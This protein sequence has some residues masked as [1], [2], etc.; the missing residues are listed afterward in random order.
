MS[1]LKPLLIGV[2]LG[3]TTLRAGLVCNGEVITE[4]RVNADLST[5]CAQASPEQALGFVVDALIEGI[6]AIQQKAGSEIEAIGISL[7]GY[8]DGDSGIIFSSPNLP[9][10]HNAD[11]ATPLSHHFGAEIRVENDAL[12]ATWGEFKRH[13]DQPKHMIYI[14]LGTGIGGGLILNEKPYRGAHGMAMEIGHIVIKPEGRPCGCGKQ[15][16]VERYASATGLSIS[17]TELTGKQLNAAEIAGL[18]EAGHG[19]A[20]A[21]FKTAGYALGQTAAHLVKILDV[22]D[23]VIGGGVSNSWRWMEPHCNQ[24]LDRDLFEPMRSNLQI[25]RSSSSD[26]AGI[27]GAALLAGNNPEIIPPSYE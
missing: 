6:T 19:D 12:A 9:G 1:N 26:Q 16:C 11:I 10:L 25:R 18:A 15:G 2:D 21:C 5:R 20:L 3:G 8:V 22:T 23:I 24:Q 14:G 27:L 7:P 4:H 13:P 17:Y